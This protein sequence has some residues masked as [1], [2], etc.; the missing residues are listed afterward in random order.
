MLA[1]LQDLHSLV[2]GCKL[3]LRTTLSPSVMRNTLLGHCFHTRN[4]KS[5]KEIFDLFL[6]FL[7]AC[8]LFLDCLHL[9]NVYVN[10]ISQLSVCS[11][12][13]RYRTVNMKSK[14]GTFCIFFFIKLPGVIISVLWWEKL[15]LRLAWCFLPFKLF[16]VP[17]KSPHNFVSCIPSFS[18]LAIE[19]HL[20]RTHLLC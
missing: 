14:G 8:L 15:Q 9:G 7:Q 17:F 4:E 2:V 6:P 12:L 11:H 3:W 18:F 1:L 19:C 13:K 16:E 10:M 20:S 5:H